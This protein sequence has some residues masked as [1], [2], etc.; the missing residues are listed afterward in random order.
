MN[1][2][3][4][5][6]LG[7][8]SHEYFH[9]WN[10]K[11]I[12]PQVYQPYDLQREVYTDLLWAFEGITSYYDDLALLRSGLIEED[13]YLELLGQTMTRVGRGLG[14]KR[15]S[16]AESSFNTWTRFYQQDENAAN[17]IVSYYAKGSLISAC[18]DLKLRSLGDAGKNLDEVMRRLWQD[19]REQGKGIGS[20]RIQ[21]L[22]SEIAGEDL[23]E[24]LHDM[25]HGT[26]ELPLEALLQQSGVEVCHRVAGNQKDKGGKEIEGDLASVDFAALLKP[27]SGGLAIQRAT[28]AGSA[29]SAGLAAGDVIV[30]IDS[31]KI[32][33]EQFEKKLLLAKPGDRWQVHA[34]R[35]DELNQF[36]VTL[37]AAEASSVVLKASDEGQTRRQAWL[38]A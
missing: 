34:F 17:A 5:E 2:D 30:A 20:D 32:N 8:C 33:L 37:Q 18:I 3:Y 9:T 11:R 26:D 15:Q 16:A 10:I 7:L 13:S 27:E 23:S 38:Q 29:Q 25:I 28:E 31:L 14:R 22:V 1:D 24:F 6:F 4:R 35:R 21:Q 36:E 19:Y 12:K